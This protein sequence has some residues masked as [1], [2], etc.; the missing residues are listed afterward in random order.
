MKDISATL[1]VSNLER[2][3]DSREEHPENMPYILVTFEV[4]KPDTSRDRSF[5]QPSNIE[6]AS[7]T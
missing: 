1:D 7:V 2:S 5:E 4:R 6:D 3:S